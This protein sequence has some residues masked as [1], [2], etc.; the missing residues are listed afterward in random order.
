MVRGFGAE[1]KWVGRQDRGD[2]TQRALRR[3]A[4][5]AEKSAGDFAE[6]NG[7]CGERELVYLFGR[8]GSNPGINAEF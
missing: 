5:N 2:L 4:E 1:V 6:M 3:R 8:A 7:L